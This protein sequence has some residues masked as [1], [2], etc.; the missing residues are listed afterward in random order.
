MDLEAFAA[1]RKTLYAVV[2][3]LEIVS[4]ASWRL[5]A[6]LQGRHPEIDWIAVAAAGNVYRHEYEG[7][8]E[9]LIWHTVRHDLTALR[10]AALIELDRVRVQPQ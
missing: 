8:D 10:S 6:E 9:N 3:A 4:E 2:R 1:D 7:V 5:P